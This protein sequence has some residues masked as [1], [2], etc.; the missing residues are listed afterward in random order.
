MTFSG[1]NS[2]SGGGAIYQLSGQLFL[3][4]CTFANN[5]AGE[6]GGALYLDSTTG[7]ITN[8]TF[9]GNEAPIGSAIYE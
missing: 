8:C 9:T 4:N 3:K 7:T 1:N 6:E 5:S 2:P